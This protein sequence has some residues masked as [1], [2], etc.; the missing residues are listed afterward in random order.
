MEVEAYTMEALV[1]ANFWQQQAPPTRT[2]LERNLTALL[3]VAASEGEPG[4]YKMVVETPG[5]QSQCQLWIPDG[6]T[7]ASQP[8]PRPAAPAH[9]P[10]A[11]PAPPSAP[12]P[13]L[14]SRCVTVAVDLA[15]QLSQDLPP[16][17]S[18]GGKAFEAFHGL[19]RIA[20]EQHG[21][22]G[23][24]CFESAWRRSLRMNRRMEPG[25]STAAQAANAEY[26]LCVSAR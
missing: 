26:Q 18:A 19:C 5:Y 1:W 11:T 6:A 21:A 22:R 13:M 16:G 4:F 17:S 7:R 9:A 3:Q 14:M 25:S 24:T 20:V 23:F 10:T 15:E 8:T 12:D 2:T